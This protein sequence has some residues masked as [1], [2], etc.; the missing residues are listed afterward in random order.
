MRRATSSVKI[1][2]TGRGASGVTADF[3]VIVRLPAPGDGTG[4]GWQPERAGAP[5]RPGPGL[6][7]K[8]P[9][10]RGRRSGHCQRQDSERATGALMT[11]TFHSPPYRDSDGVPDVIFSF[12][13]TDI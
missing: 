5:E 11:R 13:V 7:E 4:P 2:A 8:A 6:A 12:V 10:R 3:I 1:R 9:S